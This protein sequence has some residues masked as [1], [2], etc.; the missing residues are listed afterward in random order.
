MDKVYIVERKFYDGWVI[1]S[2]HA[3]E[4]GAIDRMSFLKSK[5][6]TAGMKYDYTEHEVINGDDEN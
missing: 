6:K 2:V 4:Q 1:E 3:T 5:N